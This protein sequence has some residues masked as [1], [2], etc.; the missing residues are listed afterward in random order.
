M[1]NEHVPE[2]IGNIAEIIQRNHE[3]TNKRISPTV[4]MSN[5]LLVSLSVNQRI[6][7]L[8]N[9]SNNQ[10]I[11]QSIVQSISISISQS[12]NQSVY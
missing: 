1:V 3:S 9:L 8:V 12:F 4:N 10:Y 6:Y 7:Q 5:R 11:N 2:F